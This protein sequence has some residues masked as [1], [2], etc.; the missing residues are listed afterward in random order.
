MTLEALVPLRNQIEQENHNLDNQ[1]KHRLQKLAN[2]AEKAITERD[3]LLD[4]N[5]ILCDQNNEVRVRVSTKSTMIGKAKIMSYEDLVEAQQKRD[6]KVATRYGGAKQ[7]RPRKNLAPKPAEPKR[8]RKSELEVAEH[9]I[10]IMG[11][12]EFCSVLQL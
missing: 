4:E 3:L 5:K 11:L 2:T 8:S 7:G 6:M 1:S 9:E 12:Q 10:S